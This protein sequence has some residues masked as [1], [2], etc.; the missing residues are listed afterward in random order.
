M[1]LYSKQVGSQ[2]CFRKIMKIAVLQ[3]SFFTRRKTEEEHV[4]LNILNSEANDPE[5][6]SLGTSRHLHSK[7]RM[8]IDNVLATRGLRQ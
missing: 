4:S 8:V 6:R 7:W 2:D 3:M 5:Q 1:M